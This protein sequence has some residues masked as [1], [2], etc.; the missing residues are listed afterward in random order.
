MTFNLTTDKHFALIFS[1]NHFTST[2]SRCVAVAYYW[3]SIGFALVAKLQSIAHI[4]FLR[5]RFSHKVVMLFICICVVF[6]ISFA[7][8]FASNDQVFIFLFCFKRYVLVLIYLTSDCAVSHCMQFNVT[9]SV[10]GMSVLF[11]NLYA[12][13]S[14][15]CQCVY[16]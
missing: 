9:V 14:V 12:C 10:C 1:H 13:V 7:S 2:F 8:S 15:Q 16:V 6:T 3:V 5:L 4:C 11:C